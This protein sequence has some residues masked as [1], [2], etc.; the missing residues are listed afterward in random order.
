M[1]NFQKKP[2]Q[3]TGYPGFVNKTEKFQKNQKFSKTYADQA[4]SANV[5]L[6]QRFSGK[7]G[8]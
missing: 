6:A 7:K 3:K 5:R 1:S 4:R 8:N 2:K